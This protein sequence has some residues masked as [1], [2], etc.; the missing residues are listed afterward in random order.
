MALDIAPNLPLQK[1]LISTW[2]VG[3]VSYGLAETLLWNIW[4]LWIPPPQTFFYLS[5]LPHTPKVY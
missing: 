2:S 1:R 5:A 3:S 4:L